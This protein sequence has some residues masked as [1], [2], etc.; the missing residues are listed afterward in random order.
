MAS[1]WIKLGTLAL[2]FRAS[3]LETGVPSAAEKKDS[4]V[5]INT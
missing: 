1:N 2:K 3:V 4:N 5:H